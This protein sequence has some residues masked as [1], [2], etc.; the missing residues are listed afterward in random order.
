MYLI[1]KFERSEYWGEN[2]MRLKRVES[3]TK[4]HLIACRDDEYYQV[5]DILNNKYYDPA[6]NK[7]IAIENG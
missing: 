2:P 4:E 1:G 6:G 3:V 5:I 7:W